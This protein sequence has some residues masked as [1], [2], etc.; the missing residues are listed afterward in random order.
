MVIQDEEILNRIIN[1][2]IEFLH[3]YAHKEKNGTLSIIAKSPSKDEMTVSSWYHK[4]TVRKDRAFVQHPKFLNQYKSCAITYYTERLFPEENEVFRIQPF[5]FRIETTRLQERTT[6]IKKLPYFSKGGEFIVPQHYI[7]REIH[8]DF[9]RMKLSLNRT[10][11]EI[12]DQNFIFAFLIKAT[13][14][15]L[16]R[17]KNLYGFRKFSNGIRTK[18]LEFFTDFLK[19]NN[20]ELD[21]YR[22]VVTMPYQNCPYGLMIF[23]ESK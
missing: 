8:H 22:Y 3:F 5:N 10:D 18:R 16:G 15:G 2:R 12:L 13:Q 7:N 6:E 14:A 23:E 11:K 17:G 9:V 20:R 21:N 4:I 1:N 19:D